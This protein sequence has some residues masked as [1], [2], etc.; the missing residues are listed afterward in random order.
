MTAS[1]TRRRLG[2]SAGSRTGC[3]SRPRSGASFSTAATSSGC[4]SARSVVVQ[5]FRP[6]SGRHA[7]LLVSAGRPEGLHYDCSIV[8]SAVAEETQQKQEEVDEIDVEREGAH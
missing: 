3:S 7:D 5:A 6:A 1:S 8:V 2:R 4:A